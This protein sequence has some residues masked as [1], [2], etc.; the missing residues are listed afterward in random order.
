MLAECVARRK[1]RGLSFHAN[2][3]DGLG[4][5]WEADLDVQGLG[6]SLT[7]FLPVALERCYLDRL[8]ETHVKIP[9]ELRRNRDL[10]EK[11]A[12]FL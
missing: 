3:I 9:Q 5:R 2:A 4:M 7:T 11:M 8:L 6:L 1:T 10:R 12:K